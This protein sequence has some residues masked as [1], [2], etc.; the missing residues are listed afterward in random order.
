MKKR[1]LFLGVLSFFLVSTILSSWVGLFSTFDPQVFWMLRVPRVICA[2]AVGGGLAVAGT[3]I[4][5]GLANGLADPF[6]TG[7]ASAA[8]LGA[9]VGTAIQSKIV[10]N[11][12][13]DLLTPSVFAFIFSLLVLFA[14]IFWLRKRFR[15]ATE[16]LLSGTVTG[17]F[18]SSLATLLMIFLEP[19]TWF[20][21]VNWLL[22]SFKILDI[23]Q[24]VIVFSLVL[25][26][27]FLSLLYWKQLDLLAVDELSAESAG[28]DVAVLRKKIFI[29]VAWSTAVSVSVAGV[30]G[31]LGLLVPHFLRGLGIHS[32]RHLIPLSFLL[33][34]GFLNISDLVAREVLYPSEIPVG[35]VMSVVGAPIFLILLRKRRGE[36]R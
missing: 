4:Q 34:G 5:A 30:I 21:A 18:C 13:F 1:V 9:V 29:L 11:T 2:I 27:S 26:S 23:R 17:F 28:V 15:F 35:V 19:S 3:L 24:S 10:N 31:F 33:G 8:A 16:I 32:H 12:D 36:L 20:S 14:L 6:T 7:V 22:G 25:A